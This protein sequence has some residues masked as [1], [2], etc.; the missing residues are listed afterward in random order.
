MGHELRAAL[1]KDGGGS[2]LS[3]ADA[4]ELVAKA[5]LDGDGRIS[6]DEF[7]VAMAQKTRGW[8]HIWWRHG[9]ASVV[10]QHV[11]AA[12]LLTFVVLPVLR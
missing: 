1:K 5:D 9:V 3:E 11:F 6:F 2:K 12:L 10:N 4:A 7:L 8:E